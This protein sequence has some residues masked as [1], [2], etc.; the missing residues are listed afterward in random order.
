ML[1]LSVTLKH[2]L[3]FCSSEG[4]RTCPEIWSKALV[5]YCQALKRENWKAMSGEVAQP[6]ES[7]SEENL[8]DGGGGQNH[9]PG[10]QEAG[11]QMGGDRKAAARTVR[12]G[13]H[14]HGL[15]R[16]RGWSLSILCV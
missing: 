9:L 16:T 15:G 5:C 3:F 11:E 1:T 2:R 12:L 13:Q 14:V 6:F 8:L 10:T 4:H 7:R